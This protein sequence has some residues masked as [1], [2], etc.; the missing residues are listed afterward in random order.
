[1]NIYIKFIH[2]FVCLFE[3]DQHALQNCCLL[4]A[5]SVFQA[6]YDL[7]LRYVYTIM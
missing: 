5:I 6:L 3:L 7:Y 2:Q 4:C 1:M